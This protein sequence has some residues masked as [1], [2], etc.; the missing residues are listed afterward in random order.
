MIYPIFIE[1]NSNYKESIMIL[2]S[3]LTEQLI[4]IFSIENAPNM[5]ILN[6]I[7]VLVVKEAMNVN[8]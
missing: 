6:V 4:S 2:K 7:G 5:R 1:V 3:I 8:R